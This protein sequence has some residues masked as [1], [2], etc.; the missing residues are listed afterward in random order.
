MRIVWQD[1]AEGDLDRTA[2]YILKD[3]PA[4]ALRLICTIRQ[5]TRFLCEHPNIGR[6]GRVEGTRELVIPGLPYILSY[7]IA[8]Q[9]GLRF[10]LVLRWV[11]VSPPS[12]RGIGLSEGD[13]VMTEERSDIMPEDQEVAR[14]VHLRPGLSPTVERMFGAL[15]DSSDEAEGDKAAELE[16]KSASRPNS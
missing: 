1:E 12:R 7:Q 2:G 15:V 13:L 10:G 6:T 8:G 4:A 3:D 11:G 9:R 16:E 5:A 14:R